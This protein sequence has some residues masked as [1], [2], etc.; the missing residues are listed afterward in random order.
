MNIFFRFEWAHFEHRGNLLTLAL[1]VN[2][3]RF[4]WL[5]LMYTIEAVT[6]VAFQRQCV[7]NTESNKEAHSPRDVALCG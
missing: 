1:I 4:L 2:K 5:H 6:R 7:S 3:T